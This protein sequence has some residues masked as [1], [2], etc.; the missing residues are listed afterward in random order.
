MNITAIKALI[1]SLDDQ[2]GA[3]KQS[4]LSIYS[5]DNTVASSKI[6]VGKPDLNEPQERYHWCIVTQRRFNADGFI[7]EVTVKRNTLTAFREL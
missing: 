1:K 6:S 7:V 2:G 3:C 5:V 4:Y